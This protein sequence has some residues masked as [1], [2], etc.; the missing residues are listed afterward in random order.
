[1]CLAL[2][3]ETLD[4]V[5]AKL[6][7]VLEMQPPQGLAEKVRGLKKLK[8]IADSQPKSVRSGPVQEVVLTRRRGRS[9]RAPDPDLLARRRGPVHHA[10]RGHHRRP[11]HR[12]GATSACTGC[13][14]STGARPRCTGRS[15]RTAAPT[16]CSRDGRMEV[17]VAL[18]L[19]PITAYAASAPLPKHVDEL[20]FAG[21]LRGEPV[22]LVQGEDRRARGA[23]ERRDRPRGLHRAATT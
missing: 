15:T 6:G 8:S 10:A 3:V 13:R 14:C 9:R 18:G 22:E 12:Q 1:M 5:G 19:D 20:M 4:E 2:G 17:A 7:E 11:A 21:F 23:G 16:T